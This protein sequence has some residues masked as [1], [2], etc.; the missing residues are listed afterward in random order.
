MVHGIVQAHR[1]EI[2]VES[3]RGAGTI[4]TIRLPMRDGRQ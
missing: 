1:G 2:A 3:E 4:F